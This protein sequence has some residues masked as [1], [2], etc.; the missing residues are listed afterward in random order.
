MAGLNLMGGLNARASLYIAS[1]WV[2]GGLLIWWQLE[3][4]VIEE[5]AALIVACGL[6][7]L[8]QIFRTEGATSTSSFNLSWVVYGATFAL[9]GTPETMVVIIA[10][11]LVKWLW[12]RCLWYVQLFNVAAFALAASM[13]GLAYDQVTPLG[14][15]FGLYVVLMMLMGNLLFTLVNHVMVGGVLLVARGQTLSQS[16]L[17]SRTTFFMDLGLL[18]L[19]TS[20]AIMSL[21]TPYAI[22]F[23]VV[24]LYLLQTVLKVPALQRQS[25]LDSKTELYNAAY[26]DAALE[27]EFENAKKSNR[28]LCVVMADLDRLRQINNT[29]GHLAGDTVLKQVA[30]I[31]NGTA[32]HTDVVARFGGEEF[33]ILMINTTATQALQHVEMMRKT[34]EAAEFR[35]ETNPTPLRVTL[36]FGIAARDR[37]CEHP[38]RLVHSADLAMYEA[39]HAGRNRTAIFDAT[40]SIQDLCVRGGTDSELDT[41]GPRAGVGL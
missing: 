33:V 25:K 17:L 26:F 30:Q 2:V 11:N 4:L 34:I 36:S 28:P 24:V 41:S 1:T 23:M 3:R 20:M 10:A 29:Y 12:H 32:R 39:K 8:F 37:H 5:P 7:A 38:R 27:R 14:G 21:V 16:G 35:V 9:L 18:S 31:L 15:S 22:V 40:R 6:A 13:S 19:G